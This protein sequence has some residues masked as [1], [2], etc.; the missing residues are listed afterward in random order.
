[1]TQ[2]AT[3]YTSFPP[4][5]IAEGCIQG[6]SD[7]EEERVARVVSSACDKGLSPRASLVDPSTPDYSPDEDTYLITTAQVPWRVTSPTSFYHDAPGLLE[8]WPSGTN[9]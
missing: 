3:T 6:A 7:S 2:P 9:L 8:G 4:L 1:M 5:C